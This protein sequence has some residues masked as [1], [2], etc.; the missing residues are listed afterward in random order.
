[1]SFIKKL[2]MFA[3]IG[4]IAFFAFVPFINAQQDQQTGGN[5]LQISPTRTELSAGA[6]EV[7]NFTIT[8]KNVTQGDLTAQAVVNDFESDNVSGTPQIIVD[9]NQRTPNT[10]SN[11]LKGLN[12]FDLKAGETKDIKLS[13]D[14]PGN[15]APGAYFGAVRFAA[16][17]KDQK[18]TGDRQVSLTAS[19]AHLVFLE[20]AG[21]VNEQI[22]ITG[23]DAQKNGKASSFFFSAPNESAVAIKN[24]GNGFSRPFGNVQTKNMFGKQVSNYEVNNTTPKGIILPNSS[25]TF[26]DKLE[27]VSLPGRYSQVASVAYGN[28]GE[29]VIYK[30][31]FWYMP[32]WAIIV[33]LVILAAIIYGVRR[34]IKKRSSS[35]K[36]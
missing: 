8:V 7:K 3:G 6:G 20:V 2:T 17:P 11:M 23:V 31:S 13:V 16:V 30:S 27:G 34:V 19:V 32:I 22:Q 5:G 9:E 35:K 12:D 24:L 10:I 21:D 28:G 36:S 1:M 15:A 18:A 33:L 26:V 4:V 25:R 14:V 29:V